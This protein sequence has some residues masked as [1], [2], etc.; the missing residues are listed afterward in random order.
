MT[1]P[2]LIVGLGNP[3]REYAKTRHNAGF[4]LLD[5]LAE[6]LGFR[7]RRMQFKALVADGR[8]QGRKIILAKPQTYMNL[9]GRAVRPLMRFYQIPPEQLLVAYDDLDLPLGTLRLRPK[10]GHG[11]HKGMRSIIEHLG[12]QEFPRLR[13]GIGRPPGR[14]DA[15]DYVLQPF[16]PAEMEVLQIAF[17][18]GV[19][20]I[21]RWW[22]EGLSAAMNFVN[23][24]AE[25]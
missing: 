10:G 14:M 18:R 7:F 22:E 19:E 8:Y 5:H 4:L 3:G 24:P 21:L 12:T 25:P 17:A 1:A 20:G 11:G 23:A 2:Y 6:Q 13:L 15:A 9:S 16:T